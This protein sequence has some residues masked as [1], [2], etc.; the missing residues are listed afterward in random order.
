MEESLTNGSQLAVFNVAG[1]IIIARSE[2][3]KQSHSND[4]IASAYALAMTSRSV[5]M[6]YE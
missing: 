3:T 1:L 5:S 4:E 2:A 6:R